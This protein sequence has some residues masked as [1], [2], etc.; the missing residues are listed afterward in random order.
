MNQTTHCQVRAQQRCLPPIIHQWL[1]EFGDEAYDGH[2]GVRVFFSHRSIRAME[3]VL[4]RH[5]VR[6]NQKYLQAY[7]V[8]SSHDGQVITAGWRVQRLNRA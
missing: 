5:F 2:G 4:G 8:E 7:R 1:N 6:Q 3:R